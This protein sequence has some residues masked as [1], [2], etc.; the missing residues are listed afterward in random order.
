MPPLVLYIIS[1]TGLAIYSRLLSNPRTELRSSLYKHTQG[2]T[3]MIWSFYIVY[4]VWWLPLLQKQAAY[5]KTTFTWNEP[6]KLLRSQRNICGIA[7]RESWQEVA[8]KEMRATLFSCKWTHF[9]PILGVVIRSQCFF[10]WAKFHTRNHKW[11]RARQPIGLGIS[12]MRLQVHCTLQYRTLLTTLVHV[13]WSYL[14]WFQ[15]HWKERKNLLDYSI[16]CI[17]LLYL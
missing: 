8:T 16:S 7:K 5:S 17:I 1:M 14:L 9:I 12:Y 13:I 4:K 11:I 2:R 3:V 15:L 6:S 10:M